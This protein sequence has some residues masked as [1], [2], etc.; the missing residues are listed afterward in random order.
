MRKGVAYTCNEMKIPATIFMPITTPQQKI[1]QV[2]FFG[3]DYVTIKLVGDTFDASAK[4]AQEFTLAEKRT[5][6]D[7]FDD[8]NVQAGQGT[9]AYE[10]LE[11]A[12]K[13]SVLLMQFSF[14]LVEEASFQVSQPISKKQ[15][16]GLRSLG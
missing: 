6:I 1:G 12:R 10:I 16:L 9:V 8:P 2:R 4:A 11:E 13:E 5:F 14:L 7:P 3:G 15:N